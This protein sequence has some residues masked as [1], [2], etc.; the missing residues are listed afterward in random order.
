[1]KQLQKQSQAL[2]LSV[3]LKISKIRSKM[4]KKEVM[5]EQAIT[6][7]IFFIICNFKG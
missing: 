2:P 6:L 7:P 4:A 3:G 5:K 1:M